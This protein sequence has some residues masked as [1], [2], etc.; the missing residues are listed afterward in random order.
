MNPGFGSVGF[1]EAEFAEAFETGVE[2]FEVFAE[3][4][5]DENAAAFLE[6]LEVLEVDPP[7]SGDVFPLFTAGVGADAVRGDDDL[8]VWIAAYEMRGQVADAEL[9]EL[10]LGDVQG[11]VDLGVEGIIGLIEEGLMGAVVAAQ[12]CVVED[13]V[14]SDL[15]AEDDMAEGAGE[16]IEPV[17]G[18]EGV[19]GDLIED[20]AVDHAAACVA[21]AKG[22]ILD[23][24]AAFEGGAGDG[25]EAQEASNE[26]AALDLGIAE[27]EAGLSVVAVF[28][29]L[30]FDELHGGLCGRHGESSILG[31]FL[32]FFVALGGLVA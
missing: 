9:S 25:A 13:D 3:L 11:P 28:E 32:S 27:D 20:G 4:G 5:G 7:Q 19:D 16:E 29:G 18:A 10:A 1:S 14:T 26:L 12:A 24:G 23:E 22:D 15:A 30:F 31:I 6:P 17:G 8:G 2:F 21:V